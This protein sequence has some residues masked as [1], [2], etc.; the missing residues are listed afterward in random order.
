MKI[1]ATAAISNVVNKQHRSQCGYHNIS[2]VRL[3]NNIKTDQ[4]SKFF[5]HCKQRDAADKIDFPADGKAG[6][7]NP[8]GTVKY[9]TEN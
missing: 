2:I 3:F 7:L 8:T 4:L 6:V 5:G 1:C 9:P